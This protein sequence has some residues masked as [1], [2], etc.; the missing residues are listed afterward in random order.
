M[1]IVVQDIQP[2]STTPATEASGPTAPLPGTCGL[3]FFVRMMNQE[4]MIPMRKRSASCMGH[5]QLSMLRPPEPSVPPL[6]PSSPLQAGHREAPAPSSSQLPPAN[7]EPTLTE[8]GHH[9]VFLPPPVA[10]YPLFHLLRCFQRK[11]HIGDRLPSPET[12][13][14]LVTAFQTSGFPLADIDKVHHCFDHRHQLHMWKIEVD[15]M[16]TPSPTG[17]M[18]P[19]SATR[20][21][22]WW[23]H[24]TTPTGLTGILRDRHVKKPQGDVNWQTNGFFCSATTCPWEIQTMV[25]NQHLSHSNGA[26][27]IIFGTARS[28]FPAWTLTRGG[29]LTMAHRYCGLHD[30][31]RITTRGRNTWLIRPEIARISALYI[32]E[33]APQ[34]S[35]SRLPTER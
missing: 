23:A 11:M 29:P 4:R 19:P 26:G 28:R 27:V 33:D 14:R 16:I 34:P 21:H 24:V 30:H 22:T 18:L 17:D 25:V 7:V 31:C 10:D 1:S 9:F 3:P 12:L 13:E 32:C 8:T 2:L 35:S 6:S 20:C 5:E 15:K